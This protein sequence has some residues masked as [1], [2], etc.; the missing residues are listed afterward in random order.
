MASFLVCS[1]SVRAS[2]NGLYTSDFMISICLLAPKYHVEALSHLCSLARSLAQCVFILGADGDDC[3]F[4]ARVPDFSSSEAPR[5]SSRA[6]EKERERERGEILH[7]TGNLLSMHL[8][9]CL[10]PLG[11]VPCVAHSLHPASVSLLLGFSFYIHT[12]R[13]Q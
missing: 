10:L 2:D 11:V 9:G 13:W 5:I 7:F 1:V 3:V 4:F 12:E 6:K 8:N